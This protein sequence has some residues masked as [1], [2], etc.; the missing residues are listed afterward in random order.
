MPDL[1]VGRQPIFNRKWRTHAYELLFRSGIEN[2]ANVICEDAATSRVLVNALSEIG[3]DKLVGSHQAF[4]NVTD[5]HLLDSD[6]ATMLPKQCVLEILET[7][8]P[9]PEIIAS[10]QRLSEAGYQIA[11]DDFEYSEA[12]IPLLEIADLVKLDVRLLQEEGVKKHLDHLG[13][14]DVKLLAEKVETPLEFETYQ[15]MGFDYFQG[16]FFARPSVVQVKAIPANK[17]AIMELISK[18]NDPEIGLSELGEVISRDASLSVKTLRYVNSPAV[19]LASEV[20]SVN[21]ALVLLGLDIIRQWVMILTLRGIDLEDKAPEL[22]VVMLTRAKFCQLIAQKTGLENPSSQF[23]IGLLSAI[24]VL[25]DAPMDQL[26]EPLPL[27][28]EVKSAVLNFEGEGGDILRTAI[29]MEQGM[30]NDIVFDRLGMEQLNGA[31]L[32]ALQW[33]DEVYSGI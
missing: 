14:F 13:R 11:L 6:L 20:S 31:Y 9:S 4:I 7:V 5:K 21:Q 27:T 10:V 22:F 25:M 32:E 33:A 26:I 17:L 2:Q 24:D 15:A 16:F 3:L 18:V 8:E 19:G 29:G 12:M 28:E 1:Y 23:T 30:L